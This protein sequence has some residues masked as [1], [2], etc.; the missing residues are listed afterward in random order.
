MEDIGLARHPP[1]TAGIQAA[2]HLW[3]YT[4]LKNPPRAHAQGDQ[5]CSSIY[6]G[7]VPAKSI[8][9]RDFAIN[10][11]IVSQNTKENPTYS[12]V[13]STSNHFLQFSTNNG[14]LW[15]VVAHW[16]SS[17]FL[18]DTFLRL[19]PSIEETYD[20]TEKN[21][22]WLRK[23]FP[24]SLLW[25]N[26]SYSSNFVFFT[27]V[28]GFCLYSTL[29]SLDPI[30]YSW[31]QVCDELLDDMGLRSQRSGG[32]WITWPFKIINVNEIEDLAE[33]RKAKRLV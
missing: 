2:K 23:R 33:E 17:Y 8:L 5:W 31:P 27:W 3:D 26:E 4:S 14:Y 19:P 7:I 12:Q 11:A 20:H 24:D 10:G 6:R 32:S 13:L 15:E 30:I 29:C 28:P 25:I 21:A 9:R 16:I 18:E 22:A 1:S